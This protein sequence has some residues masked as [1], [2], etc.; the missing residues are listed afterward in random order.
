MCVPF[1][2]GG[3]FGPMPTMVA[4]SEVYLKGAGRGFWSNCNGQLKRP[5]RRGRQGL[6]VKVCVSISFRAVS[7]SIRLKLPTGAMRDDAA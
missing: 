1:R 7:V 5:Q 3:F 6:S 2:E 4:A